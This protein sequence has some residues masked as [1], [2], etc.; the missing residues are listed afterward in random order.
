MLFCSLFH[1]KALKLFFIYKFEVCN[2]LCRHSGQSVFTGDVYVTLGKIHVAFFVRSNIELFWTGQ[3][4]CFLTLEL[5]DFV[6]YKI[7][8]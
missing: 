4:R 8:Q 5:L 1:S 3:H 7:L 6:P 2:T